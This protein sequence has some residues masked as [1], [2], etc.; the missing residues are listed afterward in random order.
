[1]NMRNRQAE[2]NLAETK[3]ALVVRGL[4]GGYAAN[5]VVS[6]VSFAVAAGELV[7][8][9]GANGA[10]KTTLLR[11]LGGLGQRRGGTFDLFGQDATRWSSNRLGR[12]GLLHVRE[13]AVVFAPLTVSENL[14]LGAHALG[15]RVRQ[16]DVDRT[17]ELFPI[18][19]ARA[20]QQAGT[21]SGGEQKMLGIARALVARPRLLMLDEPTAGLSVGIQRV[22]IGALSTLLDSGLAML[23]VE[24][25]L[26]VVR[27]LPGRALLL[28][29]GRITWEG[30]TA[31]VDSVEAVTAA[32][33]GKV[34][35][36]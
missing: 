1:M 30:R 9:I 6:G 33:L 19:S 12:S 16:E 2:A 22:L 23:L 26:H 25:N 21:L 32:V 29:R 8:I 17:Y 14:A 18:L 27:S 3:P 35:R 20:G 15:Y 5:D 7:A 11:S 24:Q 10:G 36:A 13:G 31:D 28:D 4:R 34:A